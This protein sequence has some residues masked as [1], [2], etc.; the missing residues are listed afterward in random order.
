MTRPS[1]WALEAQDYVRRRTCEQ[2]LRALEERNMLN[3]F[4]VARRAFSWGFACGAVITAV[5]SCVYH[6]LTH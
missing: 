4:A 2:E 6:F 5:F 1:R 3:R